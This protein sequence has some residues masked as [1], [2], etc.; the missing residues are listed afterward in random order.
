VSVLELLHANVCADRYDYGHTWPKRRP[1]FVA[2]VKELDP[3][4]VTLTECQEPAALQL[5][6]LLGYYKS[7]SFWG[8]SILY[9]PDVVTLNRTLLSE[10]WLA[11]TQTH[12][13]LMV[14]F[15]HNVAGYPT[16]NLGVSHFPPFATRAALRK[17]QLDTITTKTRTF[18]DPTFV[19]MD[20]NWSKTL[21]S[22]SATHGGWISA[23]LKATTR[24]HADYRTSGGKWGK[25]D[26]IDYV[27]G[28]GGAKFV[29]YDVLDGRKWSDHNAL[30]VEIG[31][32]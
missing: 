5:A 15:A 23:R 24:Q 4:L 12:S 13:L 29:Y 18:R 9:D 3:H 22:Y 27:I 19:A 6:K 28:R 26:P 14:E 10:R 2:K 17:R 16:F 25:G 32:W 30:N 20:A 8:S 31:G 7:V 21:E 11:G 1:A